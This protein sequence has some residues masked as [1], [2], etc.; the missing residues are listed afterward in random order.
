MRSGRRF[1]KDSFAYLYDRFK[2]VTWY[3]QVVLNRIWERESGLDAREAVDEVVSQLIDEGDAT[4]ADLL[5]SQTLSAQAVLKAIASEGRVKE[6]SAKALIDK[7]RLPV[8]STIRSLVRDLVNRNLVYK[9]AAGYSI[10]DQ[11]F[12]EWLRRLEGRT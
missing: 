10:Y 1:D 5:M 7:Y 6:I 9:S 12:A 8:G 2:G 4:Y 11:L 3:L